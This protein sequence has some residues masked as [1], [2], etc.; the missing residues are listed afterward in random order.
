M[1]VL[2]TLFARF[3]FTSTS[4][5][6]WNRKWESERRLKTKTRGFKR[7]TRACTCC[8]AKAEK[9]HYLNGCWCHGITDNELYVLSGDPQTSV[10]N[11]D[12]LKA[13]LVRM[14]WHENKVKL[15][16][17]L[18]FIPRQAICVNHGLC[19]NLQHTCLF[20]FTKDPETK[21]ILLYSFILLSL[22]YWYLCII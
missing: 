8:F 2:S 19:S 12:S 6:L 4:Q 5:W 17:W 21:P 1:S 16:P 15:H 20:G 18:L 3:N 13:M 22:H 7:P 14:Y 10:T 11:M 9:A